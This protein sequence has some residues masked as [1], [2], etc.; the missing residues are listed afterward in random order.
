[1]GLQFPMSKWLNPSNFVTFFSQVLG[2]L[3]EPL[4]ITEGI[5]PARWK[6]CDAG[7]L[8]RT[9]EPHVVGE[10]C[11]PASGIGA[12]AAFSPAVFQEGFSNSW[13]LLKQIV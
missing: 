8:G 2:H 1:M 5:F 4:G 10:Q 12:A 6:P 7:Q 3:A 13:D 9:V 11:Q